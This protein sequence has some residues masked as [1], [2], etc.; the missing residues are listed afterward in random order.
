M[1]GT[2]SVIA[3]Q[4]G[5][6]PFQSTISFELTKPGIPAP[7]LSTYATFRKCFLNVN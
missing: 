7:A 5:N 6:I 4:T 2:K 3:N 1:G